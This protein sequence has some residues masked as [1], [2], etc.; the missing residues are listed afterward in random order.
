MAEISDKYHEEANLLSRLDRMPITRSSIGIMLLLALVWIIEAFDIGVVGQ[1]VLVLKKIWNLSPGDVG[2]L[3]ISSTIGIVIGVCCAGRLIDKFGRKK[4]LI[5]GVVWFTFFTLIGAVFPN[6]YWIV[7][8]RF[9]AGLG[10]GAVFPLPYLLISEFV[11]A[12][13][14]GALAS[15]ANAILCAA[16]VLPSIIGA[17]ALAKFPLEVAWR[18]PFIAGGIPII[19]AFA[20]AKWLPESPRWLLQQ[21]R[22]EEVHKLVNRL[23]DEAG[24]EHDLNF[25]NIS[26][27]KSL[28]AQEQEKKHVGIATLFKSPYLSRSLIAW[29]LYTGTM[30]FWYA[31]LVYAPTIFANKGFNLG[32]AVLFTGAMMVIGGIGEVGIG[33]LSDTYGRKPVYLIYSVLAAVGCILLAQ[34]TALPGLI[35]GG[36]IAA[37]FG[38]GTLPCAKVYIAE[39]Y[40]TSL[41]GAGSGVGEAVARLLGGVLATYYISFILAAGGVK[42]V[43]WFVAAAFIFFVIPFMLWGQETAGLSVEETG[44]S[45]ENEPVQTEPQLKGIN[46]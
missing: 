25:T 14:R 3:G 29:G 9:V 38:F 33:Y 40:P 43:F 24:I 4:I 10:E 39:Q 12:K 37:F 20:I 7:T 26:I 32:S 41:R 46:S 2:L 13:R 34:V 23:E 21:G 22:T 5:C 27:L 28:K 8:M 35:I 45:S 1:V 19:V 18:I 6:L 15:T 30:I 42:A 36:I 16:Y 31:M 11:G 17:W 44:S